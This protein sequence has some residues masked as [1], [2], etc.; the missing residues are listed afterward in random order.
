MRQIYICQCL[1]Q[2]SMCVVV[3]DNGLAAVDGGG[4]AGIDWWMDFSFYIPSIFIY[5][6]IQNLLF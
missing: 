2:Y 3:D 6:I 4:G 1:H 5:C